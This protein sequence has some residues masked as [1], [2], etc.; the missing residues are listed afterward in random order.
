[1]PGPRPTPRY[2]NFRFRPADVFNRLY[3]PTGRYQP[4]EYRFPYSA[5]EFDFVFLTSVFTHMLP[6]DFENYLA[7]IGRVLK[8]G[9]RC[10][11]TFFLVTDDTLRT[12]ERTGQLRLVPQ[13][14]HFVHNPKVPEAAIGFRPEYVLEQYARTGLTVDLPIHPGQWCGRAE[15]LTSHDV[16][17]ATKTS[18]AARTRSASGATGLVHHLASRVAWTS[19]LVRTAF[20]RPAWLGAPPDVVIRARRFA[21]QNPHLFKPQ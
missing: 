5:N 19:R 17:V 1:V 13:K 4:W 15:G 11:S 9:G 2:P 6:R 8:P 10:L 21:R 20:R 3:N 16:V 12:A 14:N 7:E 18:S